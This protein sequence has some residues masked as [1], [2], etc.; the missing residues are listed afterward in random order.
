MRRG[1]CGGGGEAVG[2]PG[3]PAASDRLVSSPV[4]SGAAM[5]TYPGH[6]LAGL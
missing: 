6:S 5:A 1:G 4:D 2:V 3:G